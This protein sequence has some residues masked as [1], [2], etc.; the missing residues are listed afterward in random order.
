MTSSN[1]IFILHLETSGKIC[2]VALSNKS[3]LIEETIVDGEYRHSE[4]LHPAIE[5]TLRK[6]GV[7]VGNLHAVSVSAGPGSYTGLRIGSSAAKGLCYALDIPM[8]AI[9]TLRLLAFEAADRFPS[10]SQK[11][12]YCPMIDA[13]RMEV[14]TLWMDSNRNIIKHEHPCILHEID[15][16]NQPSEF[17]F[18]GDGAEKLKSLLQEN[19]RFKWIDVNLTA[20]LQCKKAYEFY[21]NNVFVD[22]YSFTPM[23]LKE[24]RAGIP[25][26]NKLG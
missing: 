12:V 11:T 24:F 1:D 8:I 18:F 25:T 3:S 21:L 10:T 13:R 26:K 6:S 4:M 22:I 9:P 19:D 5:E 17:I 23:Y 14:Y 20:S 16:E 7:K 2:S 15:W